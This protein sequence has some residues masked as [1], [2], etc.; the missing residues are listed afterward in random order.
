MAALVRSRLSTASH[1]VSAADPAVA[2]LRHDGAAVDGHAGRMR[3]VDQRAA[4]V[5]ESLLR[6][7]GGV[8]VVDAFQEPEQVTDP[9]RN[10]RANRRWLLAH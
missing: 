6:G 3:R 8:D 1:V 9:E 4:G 10:G 5:G 7:R 2:P